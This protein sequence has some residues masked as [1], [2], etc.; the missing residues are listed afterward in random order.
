MYR[1]K[2]EWLGEKKNNKEVA[3]DIKLSFFFFLISHKITYKVYQ[4]V[5]VRNCHMHRPDWLRQFIPT[6]HR[7][8]NRGVFSCSGSLKKKMFEKKKKKPTTVE[9]TGHVKGAAILK[10]ANVLFELAHYNW[11]KRIVLKS[12]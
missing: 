1:I 10:R 11:N 3:A 9:L 7:A 12:I 2:L 5:I 4:L 8:L 6:N